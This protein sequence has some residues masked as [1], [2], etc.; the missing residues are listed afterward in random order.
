MP[1]RSFH[2]KQLLFTAIAAATTTG[3]MGVAAQ[4][5]EEV[6]VTAQKRTESLQ[7]VP[8]SVSALSSTDMEGLK[9]RD[10]GEIAAQIPNLQTANPL[11]DGF[12]IFSLRGVSMSDFS[13][14]QS[15]PVASYVDEVYKGNPAIQG[16]QIYDLERIEVL[17]GPQGTLYGKNSTGGAVNFITKM[18]SFEQSG[19]LRVG[20]GDYSRKEAHGAFDTPLVE[21]ALA[22][23]LAGTWIEQDGWYDNKLP[24]VDDG[25]AIDEYGLRGSVLWQPSDALQFILRASTGKQ[26]AVNYGIQAFNIT[27]DGVGGG[28]YGLYNQLG[29]TGAV[30]SQRAGLDFFEFDSEQDEKRKIDNDAVALTVNWDLTDTLT[31]TS[32]TSWDDGNILNPE[33]ADGT[34]NAVLTT[35]YYGEAEQVSQDLRI[36]SDSSGPFNFIAGLYYAK[37]EVYNQ[38]TIGFY[39][40]LDMNTDG[41]LD[42]TDCLDVAG[43][44]FG[45]G[46]QTPAGAATEAVLN[47]FGLSLGQFFP[48]G[49]KIQND[50]DQDRTST[51]IYADTSYAF[52]DALT[53]RVGARYT[54]DETDLKNF[55]G[56]IIG[57]DNLPLF[58]TIPGD[59]DDPFATALNDDISD[60]EIT[61]KIGLDYTTESGNLYYVSF[62]HGYRNGGFNAQ[63][64][65]DPSELTRVDPELLDAWEVGFKSQLLD[66]S[67]ELNGAAFYYTYEDQQFLNVDPVTLAQTLV[68][69]DE[70]EIMGLELEMRYL[71]TERLMLR[72]GLGL[73][74]TEVTD[75]LLNGVDLEGNELPIAPELNFNAAA[76][77][78]VLET[79]LGT[80]VLRVDTSFVDDHYFEIFNVDRMQQD[81][82]WIHN[83]R[84]QFDS[85]DHDWSVAVWV[86]NLADEEYRTSNID[87][88]SSFGYDYSHIGAPRTYGAEV[89][90]HF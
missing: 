15:S 31:L 11:G 28:L 32:I 68:N 41:G 60:D 4:Q 26:E 45:L 86:K 64:F 84:L 80:L 34:S 56:R 70:S 44:T 6:V 27:P 30:D 52:N 25:N 38:T 63:A 48:A 50:F 90:Y 37:E 7:D 17:R 29:A 74:D 21:D 49:C 10:A 3:A 87:V 69:I 59:P 36:T 73:L 65:F 43:V 72:A 1:T 19:Y 67:M 89:A 83:A 20:V 9:M 88:Q 78:D 8:V 5:L 42:F 35:R 62:S 23:R 22:V 57:N 12:P 79:D 53:L 47:D 76:D 58:N 82:Y 85:G 18:P 71:V 51:A 16:V 54:R 61:G 75:G 2:C 46:P 39:T 55:S 33:D 24:G 66:G 40:D 77:W 81:G 13:L 14:N